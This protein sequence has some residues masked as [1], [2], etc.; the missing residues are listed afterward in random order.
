MPV[1]VNVWDVVRL[2]FDTIR[3]LVRELRKRFFAGEPPTGRHFLVDAPIEEIVAALGR[4]SYAPNW[5]FSYYKRGE[6]LN[7]ARVTYEERTV[8]GR[9][10]EWW[11][12]HVR[13]WDHPD[14]IAL[15]AHWELEPTEYAN[16]HLDGVGF[17]FE[18][19]MTNLQEALDR[20]ALA[21]SEIDLDR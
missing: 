4:R 10:Y 9:T 3:F 17:E 14:G 15:H 13:G 12:T 8:D 11:Q 19:G 20:S 16:D 7:L 1:S 2:P 18:R 6:I 21:Y 5:A